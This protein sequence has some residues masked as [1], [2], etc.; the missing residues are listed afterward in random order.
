V[1][2]QNDW[3]S[4][5][6][7]EELKKMWAPEAQ[8][9]V[10]KWSQVREGWPD[11][12]LHLL[13]AGVDSGTYDYFTQAIVG[14][15]HASRGDFTSSED[16]NVLV[17]GVSG[18]K[19]ALAFFGLAYYTENKDKIKAI[20][21]EDGVADNGDGPILPSEE[22]VANGTYQPLSRPIFIYVN[23]AKAE[24]AVADFVDFYLGEG[25]AL[26]AEV[27][28]VPLPA[29]VQAAAKQRF[30]DR[31]TGSVFGGDGSKIGVKA[32]EVLSAH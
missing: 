16:D 3:A 4:A 17:Q 1:N 7:T 24:G 8:D 19:L 15:E 20:P 10:M 9:A 26:A 2:P 29:G 22:T 13:G 5:I 32:D 11:E 23:K 28:Y 18:D 31:T 25:S 12:E 6:T 27:G 14:T 30:A 21:V